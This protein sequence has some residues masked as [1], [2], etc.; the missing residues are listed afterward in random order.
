MA[1]QAEEL[2]ERRP[3]SINIVELVSNA[4][5]KDLLVELVKK[6]RLDPWDV[7]IVK[8]IDEYMDAIKA[9]KVLDL[10]L[11]ANMLLAASI[12][13]RFKSDLFK[14]VEATVDLEEAESMP[15]QEVQVEGLTFRL[16]PPTKRRVTLEELISALEEAMKIKE[17]R[18]LSAS[19][20]IGLPISIN[21]IDIEEEIEGVY[22]TIEKIVDG[23][24]L[25][26]FTSL[27][28][29]SSSEDML[30]EIFIPVLFLANNG[31]I[32]IMQEEFFG[33]IIIILKS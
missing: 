28:K 30:L 22:A 31:K 17:E 13:L 19:R 2:K 29:E 15:R 14:P 7:D 10:R 32:G 23:E 24:G 1:I 27:L 18:S 20:Q 12:L 26:T 21:P 4:T 3:E 8:V 16:R 9:F 25:V 6:N 5:W 11:P 33:E